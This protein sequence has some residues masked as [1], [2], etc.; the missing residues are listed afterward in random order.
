ME[1]IF[2]KR[3]LITNNRNVKKYNFY[4]PKNIFLIGED[5]WDT[6][7]SFIKE[8]VVEIEKSIIEEYEFKY[9]FQRF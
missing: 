9:W 1:S 8:D 7:Q 5:S 6:I 3:K 4:H 2:L